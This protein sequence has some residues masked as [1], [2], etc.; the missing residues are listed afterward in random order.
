MYKQH[1]SMINRNYFDYKEV[2]GDF[3]KVIVTGPHGSG[4]KITAYIIRDDFGLTH[5][6]G[7]ERT[8][9]PEDFK[10]TLLDENDN[11]YVMF[12]PTCSGHLHLYPELLE[13]VL[14]IFMYKDIEEIKSY[15]IRN[16]IWDSLNKLEGE[17]YQ[18]VIDEDGIDLNLEDGLEETTYK[19]W[20][21]H[22]R[23]V[24]PNW[25]EIEHS[26]LK[27]HPKWIDKS[28]RKDFKEWQTEIGEK[29]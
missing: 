7:E 20:E 29:P 8:I 17:I 9:L 26:S 10:Q 6:R 23:E 15:R 24:V 13:D 2:I 4:N 18:R 3:K 22:Q 12:C 14:V 27:D 11:D 19:L 5:T 1:N 21:T 28:K 16:G 25:I